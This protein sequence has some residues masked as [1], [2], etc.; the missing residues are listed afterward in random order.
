MISGQYFQILSSTPVV[1]NITNAGGLAA[2]QTY[3]LIDWGT[4]NADG[5]TASA[6]QLGSSPVNGT[7]SVT[8]SGTLLFTTIAYTPFQQWQS[9]YFGSINNALA[10]PTAN[11]AGD[12]IT[13]LLKYA[14][15]LDP[16][17]VATASLPTVGSVPG[18][19]TLTYPKPDAVSDIVYTAQFSDDLATWSNTGV[20]QDVLADDGTTQ[21]IRAK[22]S[23]S[24]IARRFIRLMVASQ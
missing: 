22:V 13:N 6:F 2:G 5:V 9:M 20:T 16:L 3:K 4:T 23:S 8:A 19:L 10:A 15:G 18:Y 11:P 12:G 7:F 21:T 24:G 1:V 14:L 17:H